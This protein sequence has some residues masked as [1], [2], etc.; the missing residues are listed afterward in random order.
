MRVLYYNWVDYLDEENRGGGVTVYQRNLMRAEH[1]AGHQVTFLSSG[2]SYDLPA[3]GPRWEAIRHGPVRPR[4]RRYEIINSGVLSP[5]HHAFGD[6]AQL[7][8]AATERAIC[9]FI[10][11]TGPYDVIHFNNLEGVPANVLAAIRNQWPDVRLILSLHNYYPFCPQV[12]LWRDETDTCTDF[13]AGQG[14]VSCLDQRHDPRLIRLA[15]GLSYRM[16]R[17]GLRPGTWA[18]DTAFWW[19]LRLGKRASLLAG[20]MTSG[21]GRKAPTL[22]KGRAKAADF[23]ARRDR[24]VALINANCDRVLCVSD[25]VRQL[26]QH[27]GIT[28]DI[29]QTSYIGTREAALFSETAPRVFPQAG[30]GTLTL[31]Y[32]GYMRR[33]KG[34]FFLL[35]ALEDLPDAVLA[36]LRVTVA[37]RKTDEGDAMARLHA[38]GDRLAGLYHADGYSHDDLTRLLS[39]VDVGVI[40]VLWHDNLPQVAIEMHARH[41]PLLCSDMGGAKELGRCADMTFPAHDQAA[42]QACI[43]ALLA[44]EVDMDAYWKGAMVPVDMPTHLQALNAVYRGG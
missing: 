24:M 6:P 37:A 32:L 13:E 12:N 4:E 26:A 1:V 15:N 34:F 36:R 10:A 44:G 31:A 43:S 9:D 33:D 19:A 3:R 41:I 16:K 25:A 17:L 20:S 39:G 40:P 22:E 18:F 8:H 42:L 7:D 11:S 38:L 23:A 35:K 14:C 30:D 5:G 2:I 29:L 21:R 28:P 27:Y